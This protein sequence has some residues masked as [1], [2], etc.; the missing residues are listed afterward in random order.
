[1]EG[2]YSLIASPSKITSTAAELSAQG[3]VIRS[4]SS[5]MTGTVTSI[6]AAWTGANAEKYIQKFTKLQASMDEIDAMIQRHAN[7]LTEI[8][9]NYERATSENDS[10]LNSLAQMD[11]TIGAGGLEP[12]L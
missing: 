3:T 12:P 6:S 9:Q 11:S 1:M 10:E 8:A 5:E 2:S 7:M 4:L